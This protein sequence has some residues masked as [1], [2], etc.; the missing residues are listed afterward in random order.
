[1]FLSQPSLHRRPV[2]RFPVWVYRRPPS[3]NFF[4][5]DLPGGSRFVLLFQYTLEEYLLPVVH[6]SGTW[7]VCH[8]LRGHRSDD[9]CNTSDNESH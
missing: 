9:S 6:G 3:P 7:C 4:C 1:M 8:F 2:L 5:H